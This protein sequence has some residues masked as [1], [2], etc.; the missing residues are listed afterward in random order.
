MKFIHTADLHID[1][2]FSG[3]DVSNEPIQQLVNHANQT[4]L[5]RI[6]DQCIEESVDFLLIV[7]DT[8]HQSVSSIRTQA[9]IIEEFK[10]LKDYDIFVVLSFGNHDY[11]TDNRYWFDWPENV[12]WFTEEQVTTKKLTLKNNETVAISGFS[13][14]NKWV[15]DT[16][17]LEF[18]MR[19]QS[20]DYHIGFYHG[21]PEREGNYAPFVVSDLS[22]SYDYW[23]LGHIHKSE[24]IREHPATVYP[25]TPQGHNRK[26]TQGRG[27]VSVTVD[28]G[29][30]SYEFTPKAVIGWDNVMINVESVKNRQELLSVV[31]DYLASITT[32][33]YD[34]LA[35]NLSLQCGKSEQ[36]LELQQDQKAILEYIQKKVLLLSDNQKCL[37]KLTLQESF[38]DELIMGFESSL[39]DDLSRR[40]FSSDQFNR[41][42]SDL[43]QQ[44]ALAKYLEWTEQDINDC[45]QHSN[46]LIKDKIRFKSEV[47]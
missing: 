38:K 47:N 4:V 39:I 40:F 2:P 23:A 7:G 21:Q 15:T 16:K 11:Y 29:Q 14:Q 25:G 41:V 37:V 42:G 30:T 1:Q 19:D 43:L 18:P 33:S 44:P 46:Q 45:L 31:L 32:D 34:L 5:H 10:R 9:I 20:T 28:N 13:Y 3:I 22:P 6:V 26:E 35:I 12:V 27:I 17:A 8:F 24:V 36:L